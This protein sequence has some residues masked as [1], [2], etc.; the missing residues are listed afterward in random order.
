MIGFGIYG[1]TY[2]LPVFL[3]RVRGYNSLEIGT[4]V[5]VVGISQ[6]FS[7]I[8][9]AWSSNQRIDPR[10]VIGIGLPAVRATACG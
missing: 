6:L 7:T 5:F 4:T 2:L 9:A 1:S 10:I 8:F 3:G